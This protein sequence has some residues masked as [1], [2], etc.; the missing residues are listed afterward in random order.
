MSKTEAPSGNLETQGFE[1]P[2][3]PDPTSHGCEAEKSDSCSGVAVGCS[4]LVA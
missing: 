2:A 3:V 1:S 4:G